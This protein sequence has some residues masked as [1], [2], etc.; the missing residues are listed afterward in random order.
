MIN[1]WDQKQTD[2]QPRKC[3]KELSFVSN[4]NPLQKKKLLYLFKKT[5]SRLA[6]DEVG[7]EPGHALHQAQNVFWDLPSSVSCQGVCKEFQENRQL[8]GD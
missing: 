5:I 7:N 8:T 1:T 6:G 4:H 3:W 2:Q